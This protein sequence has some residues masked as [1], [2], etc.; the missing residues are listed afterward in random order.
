MNI[1]NTAY[2]LKPERKFFHRKEAV[3]Y[4]SQVCGYPIAT[5]TL[6]KYATIGGGP[7][8]RKIG[9]SKNGRVLYERDDLERWATERISAPRKNTSEV[10]S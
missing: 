3:E 6:A 4:L 5:A 1:Q 10:S 2:N 9:Q 8:F 7:V